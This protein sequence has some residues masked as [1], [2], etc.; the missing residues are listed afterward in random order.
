MKASQVAGQELCE[1]HQRDVIHEG[2]RGLTNGKRKTLPDDDNR[3]A[4]RPSGCAHPLPKKY[5]G[6]TIFHRWKYTPPFLILSIYFRQERSYE[7]RAYQNS[8]TS[9]MIGQ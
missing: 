8:T 1:C 6:I 9:P 4:F 7:N 2:E 3:N 5:D